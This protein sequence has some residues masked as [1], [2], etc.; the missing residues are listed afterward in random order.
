MNLIFWWWLEIL[1]YLRKILILTISY[2]FCQ[3]FFWLPSKKAQDFS[4]VLIL[5]L[6]T[7]C[8]T[9]PQILLLSLKHEILLG[10]SKLFSQ[11]I[12]SPFPW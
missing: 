8:N 6:N 3:F 1:F 2:I 5:D 10:I 9:K 7:L 12:K 4:K 11:A